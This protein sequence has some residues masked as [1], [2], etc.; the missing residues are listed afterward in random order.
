MSD[1][2]S[3]SSSGSEMDEDEY[4]M[5]SDELLG[6]GAS[7]GGVSEAAA[8]PVAAEAAAGSV[9]PTLALLTSKSYR[10]AL[11]VTF[12]LRHFESSQ[13]GATNFR[14]QP[15][16]GNNPAVALPEEFRT[17][18]QVLLSV[19]LHQDA[20][21][22]VPMPMVQEDHLRASSQQMSRQYP[23]KANQFWVRGQELGPTGLVAF[24]KRQFALSSGYR[25]A[26]G[27][28]W[29]Q[30]VFVATLFE[31]G[32][33]KKCIRST[34]FEVRSKEQSNKALA[35][36]GLAPAKRKRRRTPESEARHASLRVLQEDIAAATAA[37][38]KQKAEEAANW[39][40]LLFIKSILDEQPSTPTVDTATACC[41]AL[42]QTLTKWK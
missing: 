33:P 35:S 36:R 42:V 4:Q 2:E 16:L 31:G 7:N 1:Y 23:L 5:L 11:P 39:R 27:I 14:D 29:P 19:H 20:A 13:N 15:V 18:E 17:G 12:S 9:G 41:D 6:D 32:Q 38:Q 40:T 10:D 24:K 26:C 30:F 28:E 22:V 34:P 25:K 21:G 8:A 3:D 37:I